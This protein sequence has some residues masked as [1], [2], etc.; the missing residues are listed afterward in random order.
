MEDAVISDVVMSESAL[1]D[2]NIENIDDL[3]GE[4]ADGLPT[5]GLGIALPAA[6]LPP[7]LVLRIIELQTRGCCT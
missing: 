7:G 1:I 3:F 5:D 4:A 6:P 2:A